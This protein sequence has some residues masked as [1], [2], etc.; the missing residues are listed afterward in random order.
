MS[1]ED[2]KAVM[3]RIYDEV[4]SQGNIDLADEFFSDDFVDHEHFPGLPTE[5]PEAPKAGFAMLRA[6]FPDLHMTADEMIAERD[7]V[8]TRGTV[9]GT[10]QGEFMGI[11]PTNKSFE[12][13]FMD[14]IE[15]H[16]G[17]AT[18]HWGLTD[19]GA[20]MEQLGIAPPM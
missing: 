20:M 10:H 8:V 16:D 13:Q 12:V 19:Q 1:V 17:K 9:S 3:R 7:K 14:I 5:G 18:E 6:A 15:F 4:M 2:N 11:P